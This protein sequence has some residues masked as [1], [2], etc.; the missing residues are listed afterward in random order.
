MGAKFE[1]TVLEFKEFY[2][3]WEFNIL[4]TLMHILNK[5]VN[6]IMLIYGK[7]LGYGMVFMMI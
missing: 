7:K 2:T 1:I 6:K 3:N 4:Y 5:Y